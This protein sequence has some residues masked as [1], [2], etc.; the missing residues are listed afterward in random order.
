[1]PTILEGRHVPKCRCRKL[2]TKEG[3]INHPRE[4]RHTFQLCDDCK[5]EHPYLGLPGS[6]ITYVET[7]NPKSLAEI[8]RLNEALKCAP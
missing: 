4:G 6:K 8:R 1:M 5:P 7:F 2:A 3:V